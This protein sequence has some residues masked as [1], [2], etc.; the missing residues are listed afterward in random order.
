[1]ILADKII[2]LRKK[3]G[4]S[5]EELAEKMNVSRQSVSKWEGAQSVPDIGKILQMSNIFGVSTDY[6][7]KDE[8]EEPEPGVYVNC[9]DDS[10]V[11]RVSMEEASEFLK[12]KNATAAKIAAAVF[13]CIISPVCMLLLDGLSEYSGAISENFA[14]G[15]GLIV[16][17]VIVSAAVAVFIYCGLRTQKFE[18]LSKEPIELDYGVEGMVKER[19]KQ[20]TDSHTKHT[21]IGT[22]LCIA[23][24]IPMFA[25]LCVTENDMPLIIALNVGIVLAAF[26]VFFLVKSGIKWESLQKLLQE[27]DYTV[28]MKEKSKIAG[29]VSAI[30]WLAVTAGFL[31]FSYAT[32]SYQSGRIIWPVAGVLYAAV[33][34]VLKLAEKDK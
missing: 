15:F 4:W 14:G 25:V 16:L 24:L 2:Q 7:L 3:S 33:L 6:L 1:M 11:H 22:C 9:D 27:E 29:P 30:Y 17:L 20:M 13:L 10:G 5:Q 26:G 28:K 12:V 19:Q 34:A 21:V 31:I 8:V 23:S 32:D 18:Y